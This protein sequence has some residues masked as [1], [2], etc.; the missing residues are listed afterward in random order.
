[1]SI[2]KINSILLRIRG[3]AVLICAVTVPVVF[4]IYFLQYSLPAL[5]LDFLSNADIAIE[6]AGPAV[7]LICFVGLMALLCG[8]VSIYATLL[9]KAGRNSKNRVDSVLIVLDCILS[10]Y[11]LSFAIGIMPE[12]SEINNMFPHIDFKA[13]GAILAVYAVLAVVSDILWFI[14]NIKLKKEQ[15]G[16]DTTGKSPYV[17]GIGSLVFAIFGLELAF[18]P[19][20]VFGVNLLIKFLPLT[21][22]G[23][24]EL[25]YSVN[26]TVIALLLLTVQIIA[27]ASALL[28]RKSNKCYLFSALNALCG[29][30]VAACFVLQISQV[31]VYNVSVYFGEAALLVFSLLVLRDHKKYVDYTDM[32]FSAPMN[33]Y[34]SD[35]GDVDIVRGRRV[36]NS[37]S[38]AVPDG[39]RV[40]RDFDRYR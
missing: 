6:N 5:S 26:V 31:L 27:V 36:L 4:F 10:V 14:A 18:V 9:M 34:Y 30:G 37:R 19:G 1:M 33:R 28:T 23:A 12:E 20:Y 25:V 24:E 21:E 8:V 38:Y 29:I 39:R 22:S 7:V 2:F 40:E 11:I 15:A 13:V 3:I 35:D 16:A 17:F 32:P